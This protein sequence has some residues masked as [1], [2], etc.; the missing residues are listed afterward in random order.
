MLTL[1]AL[2]VALPAASA[3]DARSEN[4]P[5]HN[6]P[7]KNGPVSRPLYVTQAPIVMLKDLDSGA[8]LFSRGA[9]KRFA[10]ASMAKVMTAYVVLD[11]IKKGELDRDRQFTVSEATW[12]KW[13]GSN[14]G[15]TMFLRPNE[16]ISVDALLKGLITVSGNDAAAALAV[17]IDGSEEEFVKRMNVVATEIGM[18][19]SRFGTPNGW[20]DG[21]VT[22]VSAADLITLADRLI[23]DHPGGYAR[24][25]SLPKLQHGTSPDGKPIVQPNR[26][27]ILGRFEGAD[28]LKTG[29]T[30]EAGYC[31]LGSAKRGGRRLIMVVAGM[32]SEKARRDEAERLMTWGFEAW[33]G[34]ELLPAGASVGRLDVG[35]GAKPAVATE[36]GMA[37]R[38][39]VPKGY[40][41]GYRAI[42]R[43]HAPLTA[44]V[45]RGARV[46][47]LVVRPDGLPPQTTP[48]LAAADV[49]EG[50]GWWARARTGFYRLTGL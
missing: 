6:A 39:T 12:K 7:A 16:K 13:N 21:G 36:T 2:A 30:S 8:I 25:F 29:H 50:G 49:G 42:M 26:N 15:S 32:R 37:V 43:S 31:F 41:G 45:A 24:Y 22:K 46:A 19:S 14:G 18:K 9:D 17:G 11:L 20:P 5:V 28:G 47:D 35:S 23:R 33:E 1:A 27:P 4:G 48:L 40:A 34:R 44:P 10:P 3:G 38:M